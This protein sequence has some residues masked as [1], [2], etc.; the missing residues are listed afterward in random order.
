MAGFASFR[1]GLTSSGHRCRKLSLMRILMAA[2]A[3]H[4]AKMELP[5]V[6]TAAFL[7]AILARHGGMRALQSKA[8]SLMIPN[9]EGGRVEAVHRVAH[10][11]QL[12]TRI[13]RNLLIPNKAMPASAKS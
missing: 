2:H 6:R 10:L 1:G 9:A 3:R 5:V 11:L 8:G 4:V 12:A 7:V 13:G